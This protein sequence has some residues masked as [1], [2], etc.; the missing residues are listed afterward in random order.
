MRKIVSLIGL[1]A[2]LFIM[3]F[4][5]NAQTE[6]QNIGYILHLAEAGIITPLE[7][8]TYLMMLTNTADFNAV[9]VTVPELFLFN[10]NLSDFVGDWEEANRTEALITTGTLELNEFTIAVEVTIAP[11]GYDLLDDTFSYQVRFMGDLPE[12]W[13][14]KKGQLL[15]EITFDRATLALDVNETFRAGLL[16]GYEARLA[17]TR[18]GG[19]ANPP[20]P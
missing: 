19:S 11:A 10:Y 15:E 13:L 16:A 14:D 8:D 5:T 17:S 12:E 6:E 2:T 4:S 1:V 9:V 7:E 18:T 20:L 3:I